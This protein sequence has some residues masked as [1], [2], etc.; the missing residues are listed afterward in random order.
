MIEDNLITIIDDF[1]DPP[2]HE[3]FD[4]CTRYY[5]DFQYGRTSADYESSINEDSRYFSKIVYNSSED[6]MSR[7]AFESSG[8]EI[9]YRYMVLKMNE[10]W[11]PIFTFDSSKFLTES[12]YRKHGFWVFD[13]HLNF[14][15]RTMTDQI[16]FDASTHKPNEQ[17]PTQALPNWNSENR[18][19]FRQY[20]CNFMCGD[21][22]LDNITGF[23]IEDYGMIPWKGNRMVIFPSDY[24]HKAWWNP[25]ETSQE[26]RLTYTMFGILIEYRLDPSS[27]PRELRGVM[28]QHDLIDSH[29]YKKQNKERRQALPNPD[30]IYVPKDRIL[31]GKDGSMNIRK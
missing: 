8:D 6:P 29:N 13:I 12:Q 24:G 10:K 22:F 16:H 28:D 7:H 27:P 14:R 31:R 20:T 19:G 15:S 3:A 18:L 9:I 25:K 2:M 5:S 26:M 21:N 17:R 30:P 1:L 4:F 23:E 11:Q